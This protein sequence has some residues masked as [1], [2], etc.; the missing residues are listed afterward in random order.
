MQS[1]LEETNYAVQLGTRPKLQSNF[2]IS[3]ITYASE[4]DNFF[5]FKAQGRCTENMMQY[6]PLHFFL[7]LSI[8]SLLQISSLAQIFTNKRGAL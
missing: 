7:L 3:W 5:F 8:R 1:L 2:Q 6:F 4:K